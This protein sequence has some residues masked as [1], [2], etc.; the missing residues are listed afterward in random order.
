MKIQF[1]LSAHVI[2]IAVHLIVF[3]ELSWY[4]VE[5]EA[6]VDGQ[7][8]VVARSAMFKAPQPPQLRG[9]GGGRRPQRGRKRVVTILFR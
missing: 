5:S 3:N 8:S 7:S 2:C 1:N 6:S 4:K 9:R